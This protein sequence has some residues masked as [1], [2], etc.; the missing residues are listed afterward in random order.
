MRRADPLFCTTEGVASERALM[1]NETP[2]LDAATGFVV[3][4]A[5]SCALWTMAGL[6]VW[7]LV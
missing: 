5:L 7:Y 1:R 4:S 3:G 2:R 6:V